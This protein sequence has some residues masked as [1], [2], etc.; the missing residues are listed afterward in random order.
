MKEH[1]KTEIQKLMK[2]QLY[3]ENKFAEHTVP[4]VMT[5]KTNKIMYQKKWLCLQL[6]QFKSRSQHLSEAQEDFL[7]RI[8]LLTF[9]NVIRDGNFQQVLRMASHE[10]SSQPLARSLEIEARKL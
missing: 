6:G 5:E 2:M 9:I 8:V 3:V 1:V 7:T 4:V 10:S